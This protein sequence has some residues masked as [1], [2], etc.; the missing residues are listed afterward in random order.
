MNPDF[1][2]LA[3]VGGV[4]RITMPGLT[5]SVA[6]KMLSLTNFIAIEAIILIGLGAWLSYVGYI[7]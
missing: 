6:E 3:L 1:G 5:R 7:A 2:W 4:M